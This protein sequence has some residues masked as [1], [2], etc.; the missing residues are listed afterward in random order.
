MAR[1]RHTLHLSRA[2]RRCLSG[3]HSLQSRLTGFLR[4]ILKG[5]VMSS[6][7]EHHSQ[8]CFLLAAFVLLLVSGCGPSAGPEA[9]T[10]FKPV[11]EEPEKPAKSG[12]N[13]GRPKQEA[14]PE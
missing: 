9:N 6:S 14:A 13:S 10:K 2:N 1:A 8:G 12:E 7:H 11:D 5:R 3:S 4:R